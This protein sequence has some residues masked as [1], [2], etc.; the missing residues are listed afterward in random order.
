MDEGSQAKEREIPNIA[1]LRKSNSIL[2]HHNITWQPCVALFP[3]WECKDRVGI[4]SK[5]R[6]KRRI[7]P[8]WSPHSQFEKRATEDCLGDFT[9]ETESPCPIHFKHSHWWKRWSRCK[10]ASHYFWGT[11]GVCECKMNVKVHM[12]SYMASNGSC[13]MVTW[14]TFK[15]HLQEVG[16]TQNWE[17][18]A[19][20]MLTTIDLFYVIMCEDP[21]E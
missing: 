3:N 2:L 14:I 18:M 20:W 16:L 8:A 17:T 10:F 13:F 19:L 6:Y 11:N 9:H 12:G 5:T 7:T 21:H 1:R 4:P 15:N